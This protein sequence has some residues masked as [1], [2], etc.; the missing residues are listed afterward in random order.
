MFNKNSNVI[1]SSQLMHKSPT[2]FMSWNLFEFGVI[3]M[4]SQNIETLFIIMFNS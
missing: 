2:T 1:Q 4:M 3:F